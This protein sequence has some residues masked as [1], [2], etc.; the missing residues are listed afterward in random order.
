MT[1]I[2]VDPNGLVLDLTDPALFDY[3]WIYFVEPGGLE[4]TD[5][6][7]PILR[8]YLLNGGLLIGICF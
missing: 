3:P 6:E 8:R 4:F 2:K 7:V 5:E 1:S